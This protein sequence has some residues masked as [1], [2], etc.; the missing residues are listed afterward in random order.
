MFG[1]DSGLNKMVG[2]DY[3]G[4]SNGEE[5]CGQDAVEQLENERVNINEKV[6]Q[7]I[8]K[9]AHKM[10]NDYLSKGSRRPLR[11]MF[12]CVCVCVFEFVFVFVFFC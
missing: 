2:T 4:G 12:F 11:G 6:A 9:G 10:V 7:G 8:K 5:V 1:R 3:D